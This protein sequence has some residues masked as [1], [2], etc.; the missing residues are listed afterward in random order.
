MT[1]EAVVICMTLFAISAFEAD[2][3]R[4]S[5][6]DIQ[7]EWGAVRQLHYLD[8]HDGV[9]R[10][11]NPELFG[12]FDI[13]DGEWFRIPLTSFHH[14]NAIHLLVTSAASIFLGRL[15]EPKWGSLSFGLFLVPAM[16]V[17]VMSELC[18]G[19]ATMGFSG[20]VCAMLGALTVISLCEY[21][22]ARP[23]P[24]SACV[25]GVMIIV[26]CVATT[27]AGVTSFANVSHISGY[28]YGVA[29]S[30]ISSESFRKFWLPRACL[31]LFQLWLIPSFFLVT[32]PFWIG[33]YHWYRAVTAQNPQRREDGLVRALGHDPSLTGVYLH[34]SEISEKNADF[35]QAWKWLI[36]GMASNPSNASLMDSTRRLWRHMDSRQRKDA[37]PVLKQIFGGRAK[38]WMRSIRA[39]SEIPANPAFDDRT[40]RNEEKELSGIALDQKVELREFDRDTG[41]QLRSKLLDPENRFEDAVEG[42][43]F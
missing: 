3:N 21:P 18:F 32:H 22:P 1:T 35:A 14:S 23:L 24:I 37:E 9:R 13:W 40:T 31:I 15:L 39:N 2:S 20:V 5:L 41:R 6:E 42:Q 12:P 33:R 28:V 30:A 38:L 7:R 16:G 27:A 17:S 29:V 19:N 26:L 34:L 43:K 11:K 10:S 8:V 25:F 4:V 36:Q